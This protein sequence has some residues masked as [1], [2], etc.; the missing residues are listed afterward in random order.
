MLQL[1]TIKR[2]LI[3]YRDLVKPKT[4]ADKM[5]E[6]HLFL[7]INEM[8]ERAEIMIAGEGFYCLH[9]E[10]ACSAE[11]ETAW[12]DK[13][14][15]SAYVDLIA[16]DLLA[17]PAGEHKACQEIPQ[18]TQSQA[19]LC[20]AILKIVAL[21]EA[22]NVGLAIPMALKLKKIQLSQINNEADHA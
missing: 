21:A 3:E 2:L 7:R 17:A 19:N 22:G 11:T 5:D 20:D 15:L 14:S 4:S 8:I 16:S 10:V 18:I 6:K 12:R 9:R 1:T 13:K